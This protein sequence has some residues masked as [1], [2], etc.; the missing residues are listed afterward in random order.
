MMHGPRGYFC[1]GAFMVCLLVASLCDDPPTCL[2]RSRHPLSRCPSA[3]MVDFR[4]DHVLIPLRG[5]SSR[6]L[7]KDKTAGPQELNKRLWGLV[8]SGSDDWVL[9]GIHTL[10]QDGAEVGFILRETKMSCWL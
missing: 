6:R 7:K 10:V 4:P 1:F 9:A 8:S 2:L 3:T 5:G